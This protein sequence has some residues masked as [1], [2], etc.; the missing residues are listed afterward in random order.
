MTGGQSP[1][2]HRAPWADQAAPP[3]VKAVVEHRFVALTR[4]ARQS[5]MSAS[6]GVR[7]LYATRATRGAT[8]CRASSG[9]L[10]GGD[11]GRRATPLASAARATARATALTT[12]RLNTLGM[13]YSACSSSSATTAA[14]VPRRCTP[15]LRARPAS[16]AARGFDRASRR[17][18][19]AARAPLLRAQSGRDPGPREAILGTKAGAERLAPARAARPQTSTVPVDEPGFRFAFAPMAW[20]AVVRG[21]SKPV[22]RTRAD[23]SGAAS[24]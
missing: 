17:E 16:V 2:K 14:M 12:A 10:G 18:V 8:V 21:R 19:E 3:R 4:D 6:T 23:C 9:R 11:G 15:C 20:R 22:E 1:T 13:M 24:R 7:F 5:Q